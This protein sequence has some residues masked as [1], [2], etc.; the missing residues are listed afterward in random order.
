MGKW[1]IL[2]LL[3]NVMPNGYYMDGRPCDL[4]KTPRLRGFVKAYFIN[5]VNRLSNNNNEKDHWVIAVIDLIKGEFI[6]WGITEEMLE[7]SAKVVRQNLK[8]AT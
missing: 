1:V 4:K 7:R 5:L 8:N 3:E 6:G 2:E